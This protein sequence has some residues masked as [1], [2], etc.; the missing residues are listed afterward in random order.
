MNNSDY[1]LRVCDITG[2]V[3]VEMSVSGENLEQF[4]NINIGH[5]SDGIYILTGVSQIF[6]LC[7]TS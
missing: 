5:L 2:E 3:V 1:S 7:N 6:V 4:H